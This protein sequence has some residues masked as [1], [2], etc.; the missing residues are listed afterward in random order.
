MMVVA[1]AMSNGYPMAAV[2]GK[3]NIMDAAQT[4]FISSTYWTERIGPTAAIA[5]IRKM[6]DKNVPAHLDIIGEVIGRGWEK[7]AKDHS[8]DIEIL[9]PNALTTFT[10]NYE[11][12]QELKT[13]FTQEMLKKGYLAGSS[14]YVSYCH[15]KEIVENYLN[16][17]DK[18][19][20]ILAQG[21]KENKI[22]DLLEGPVAHSGFQRLT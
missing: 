21:I 9:P 18:V 5:T 1:K 4:S 10:F 12:T 8:L 15:T 20:K 2:I 6:Q 17:V 19:F 13:L 11:N 3:G 22:S 16:A 14:V 7:L